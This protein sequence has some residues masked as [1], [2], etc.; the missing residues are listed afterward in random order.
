MRVDPAI[1]TLREDGAVQRSA[2]GAVERAKLGWAALPAV[3]A[4]LAELECYGCGAALE[5]C[6]ALGRSLSGLSAAQALVGPLVSAMADTLAGQPLGHVPFRHQVGEGM[7]VLQLARAGRATLSLIQYAPIDAAVALRSVC[8]TDGERREICLAGMADARSVTRSGQTEIE[9]DL[10]FDYEPIEP[11][12]TFVF[13]GRN[14]T[15]IVDRVVAPL[16]LLRLS[17][18]SEA[19]LPSLEYRLDDGALLHRAAGDCRESRVEL[20]LALL[21][22]M[23][24]RDAVPAMLALT[25][26]GSDS[27]RWQALR[28]CLAL[29]SAAGFHALAGI[30]RDAADPLH[31][32]A[33]ELCT[34]LQ[35][36]YPQLVQVEL[37]PCPA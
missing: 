1:R 28:E 6:R 5:D 29:D 25:R 4:T 17:R 13:A 20:M 10:R 16:T 30:A 11:G 15:K 22:R 36:R 34:E 31:A 14:A 35:A 9:S 2:Q 3:A 21:G 26:H 32:P 7:A 33:A 37:E 8:F 27:L 19:P 23:G 24:R 18:Q 12:S